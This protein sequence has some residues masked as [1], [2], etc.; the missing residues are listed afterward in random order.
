MC[1]D[2]A[3]APTQRFAYA[4]AISGI[5]RVAREEGPRALLKGL[6]PNVVR[7]V[8]MSKP[9]RCHIVNSSLL[10]A[11]VVIERSRCHSTK[12]LS[13]TEPLLFPNC[14]PLRPNIDA[15]L[16]W[17]SLDVSQIAV[18]VISSFTN[19]SNCQLHPSRQQ[20]FSCHPLSSCFLN[21]TLLHSTFPPSFIMLMA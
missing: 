10:D 4:N 17:A 19:S 14:N 3:K 18:C 1:A 15:R 9:S 2:G 12:P 21:P 8:L 7:S 5:I 13:R 6:G 20:R 11:T 16:T